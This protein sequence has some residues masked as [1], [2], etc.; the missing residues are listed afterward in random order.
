MSVNSALQ[1]TGAIDDVPGSPTPPR[2]LAAVDDF[3]H[4][5]GHLVRTQDRLT[6]EVG[7]LNPSLFQCDF[8]PHRCRQTEGDPALYLH[9]DDRGIDR[10]AAIHPALNAEAPEVWL[11]RHAQD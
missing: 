4:Y 1:T 7:L 5:F 3:D 9:L 6:V 8:F 11:Y 2:G 10:E